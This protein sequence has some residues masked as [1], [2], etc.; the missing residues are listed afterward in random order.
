VTFDAAA[1]AKR[2]LLVLAENYTNPSQAMFDAE[3][4]ARAVSRELDKNNVAPTIDPVRAIDLRSAQPATYREMS[5]A[6]IGRSLGAQQVLYIDVR[7]S[8]IV[9]AEASDIMKATMLTRVRMIDTATGETLWPTDAHEGY[10][11][12]HE[13]P[14]QRQSRQVTEDSLRLQAARGMGQRIARLFYIYQSD[15][16][17]PE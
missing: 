7:V 8:G 17:R 6:E 10:Q 14:L 1:P 15:E 4:L 12:V 2:P 5:I 9:M 11:L 13:T 16:P 3:H